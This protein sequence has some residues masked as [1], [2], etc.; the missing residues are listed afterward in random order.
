MKTNHDD[1]DFAKSLKELESITQWFESEEVDLDQALV[2]FERGMELAALLKE[3]LSQVQNKVE[4]IK[5][6]FSAP[7]A[8]EDTLEES[9]Q[10]VPTPDLFSGN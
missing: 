7:L 8:S 2:K 5:Q 6:K 4:K 9:D 1:I 3:H 10:A